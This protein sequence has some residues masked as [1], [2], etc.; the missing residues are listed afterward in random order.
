ML[1]FWALANTTLLLGLYAFGEKV[2][3]WSKGERLDTRP[4]PAVHPLAV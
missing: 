1:D 4:G 3:A 2:Q